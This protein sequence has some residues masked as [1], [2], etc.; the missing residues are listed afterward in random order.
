VR[1]GARPLRTTPRSSPSTSECRI[2]TPRF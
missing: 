1:T 2:W